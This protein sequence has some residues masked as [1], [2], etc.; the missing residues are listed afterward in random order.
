MA[1]RRVQ[2]RAPERLVERADVL[3]EV[4]GKDRTSI[5][6]DALRQYLREVGHDDSV[7]QEIAGAYYDDEISFSQ[8]KDLVGKEEA[9][10][11]RVLKKQL[12]DDYVKRLAAL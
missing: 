7:K 12:D 2:F 10:S 1:S 5:L 9:E 11:F 3:A 8:L 6:L 4:L